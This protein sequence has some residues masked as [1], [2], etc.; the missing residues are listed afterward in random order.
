VRVITALILWAELFGFYLLLARQVDGAEWIAGIFSA[1]A[2]AALGALLHR[3]AGR[4]CQRRSMW[5]PRPRAQKARH[6]ARSRGP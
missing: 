4:H 3:R 5:Q 1:F 2:A 6:D